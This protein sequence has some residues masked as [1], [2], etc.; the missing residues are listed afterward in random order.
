M[1]ILVDQNPNVGWA[2]PTNTPVGDAHPT[3][4]AVKGAMA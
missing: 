2:L 3:E 1:S 4:S